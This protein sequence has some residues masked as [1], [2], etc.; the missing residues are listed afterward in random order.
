MILLVLASIGPAI[1]EPNTEAYFFD[2]TP[3]KDESRF[4]GPFNTSIDVNQFVAKIVSS[5]VLLCLPFRYVF[6]VFGGGM[7]I[8][9][10]LCF[11]IKDVVEKHGKK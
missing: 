8:L 10:L 11:R 4:Y 5:I 3:D 7:I 2:I 9:F 1:L 6:L